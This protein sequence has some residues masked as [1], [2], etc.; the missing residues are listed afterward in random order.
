MSTIRNT[1][2]YV[3]L[4]MAQLLP[5]YCAWGDWWHSV[6]D[7]QLSCHVSAPLSYPP[8]SH[9]L[10]GAHLSVPLHTPGTAHLVLTRPHAP[11]I[12]HLSLF[13]ILHCSGAQLLSA[14]LL[15]GPHQHLFTCTQSSAARAHLAD[16]SPSC[17]QLHMVSSQLL[18]PSA[19]VTL[20][21]KKLGMQVSINYFLKLPY[22]DTIP[23]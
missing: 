20:A 4:T 15:L 10:V 22:S 23:V 17:P 5:Y 6:R 11:A 21:E 12:H 9:V 16:I 1:Q 13:V 8:S 3:Y 14:L 19:P 18:T 7:G 2:N